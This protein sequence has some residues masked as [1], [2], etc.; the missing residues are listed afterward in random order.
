MTGHTGWVWS[1]HSADING[2]PVLASAGA[3]GTV[4]LWDVHAYSAIG[5]PIS[6]HSDQARAVCFITNGNG[7]GA[8]AS[9]GHDRSIRMWD[10][11]TG[12]AIGVIPLPIPVYALARTLDG[13][14]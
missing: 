9:A 4:R 13:F 7:L 14:N 1:V 3:D 11:R 6:A 8:L 2:Q 5:D 12:D 10:S